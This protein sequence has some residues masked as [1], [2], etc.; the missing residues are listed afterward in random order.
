MEVTLIFQLF[1]YNPV[2]VR[3]LLRSSSAQFQETAVKPI[4]QLGLCQRGLK[5]EQKG[6]KCGRFQLSKTLLARP[7]LPNIS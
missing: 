4:S 6:E 2:G 3:R 5:N 7:N 1:C